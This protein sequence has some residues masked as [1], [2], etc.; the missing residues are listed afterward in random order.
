MGVLR[1]MNTVVINGLDVTDVGAR[2]LDGYT[3][4]GSKIDIATF[5]GRGRTHF[6]M[7]Q[8]DVQLKSIQFTLRF[9]GKNRHDV[10]LQKSRLDYQAASGQCELYMPDGFYYLCVAD[11]I[12]DLALSG[13]DGAY[14]HGTADY[15]F[16]GICHDALKEVTLTGDTKAMTCESTAGRTDCKLSC[17]LS[18]DYETFTLGPVTYTGVKTG[19]VLTADGIE[20]RI[21]IDGA[22]APGNMTFLHFPYLTA[23]KNTITCSEPVTVSYY[24]TYV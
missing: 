19:Q 10:L 24:P 21:L 2:L 23:G 15:T 5:K 11:T 18:K 3:I 6:S 13:K 17:T 8:S 14:V 20:G 1:S 16:N 7:A 9:T 22:P 4:G 12:G